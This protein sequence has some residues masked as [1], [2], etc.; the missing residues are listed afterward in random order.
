[1]ETLWEMDGPV[2]R[3]KEG[4]AAE[5][6]MRVGSL[7]RVAQPMFCEMKNCPDFAAWRIKFGT[8]SA[9]F[10]PRHALSTMRNRRLW[11]RT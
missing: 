4:A 1:M 3:G 10:C 9:D 2:Y 11:S 7:E 8:Q 5:G 6:S